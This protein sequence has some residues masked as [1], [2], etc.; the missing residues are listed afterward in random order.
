MHHSLVHRAGETSELLEV[1]NKL[2]R[3]WNDRSI[4]SCTTVMRLFCSLNPASTCLTGLGREYIEE[5]EPRQ[6]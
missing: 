3:K 6:M 1:V 4:V 2:L 5:S